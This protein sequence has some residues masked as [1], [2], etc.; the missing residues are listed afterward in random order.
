AE[1]AT[2]LLH[3][4]KN[5]RMSNYLFIITLSFIHYRSAIFTRVLI[6]FDRCGR[7][8]GSVSRQICAPLLGGGGRV[9]RKRRV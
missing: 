8:R 1:A 7:C 9:K 3:V 4:C 5:Y 6:W 2:S